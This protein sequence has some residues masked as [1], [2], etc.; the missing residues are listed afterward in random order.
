MVTHGA[1]MKTYCGSCH[2]GAITFQ[3]DIDLSQGSIKCNCSICRKGRFWPA[4]VAPSAFRLLTGSDAL[5]LYQFH[6][7]TDEHFFCRH[8]GIRAFGTGKSPRWGDFYA[9]SLSCLD[10]ISDAEMAAVPVTY[11]DGRNDAWDCTP[12]VTGYL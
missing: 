9:V 3:A 2:C 1:Y 12:A 6:S 7:K 11:I 5:T 4:I 8:C 10:D